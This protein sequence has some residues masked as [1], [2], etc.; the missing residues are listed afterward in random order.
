M[1]F[2]LR[3]ATLVLPATM[4]MVS[5]SKDDK[6][7]SGNN[8]EESSKLTT[9]NVTAEAM[10]EDANTEIMVATQQNALLKTGVRSEDGTVT[11]FGATGATGTNG[12]AEVVV[13]PTSDTWPKTVVI[14][15]GTSG[16]TGVLGYTHKGKITYVIT[17]RFI[18][19]GSEITATFENYSVNG[20]KIEGTYKVVNAT[21][22]IVP[23]ITTQVI[24]GKITYPDGTWYTHS[25]LRNFQ[26][27]NGVQTTTILEDDEFSVTGSSSI[28][29]SDG[30][31]LDAIIKTPL[32]KK[33][34]CANIVSGTVDFTYNNVS[35]VWSYGTGDC[36]KIATITVG[37]WVGTITLP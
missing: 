9:A 29:A 4:L 37:N 2:S 18:S 15:Y 5:C 23:A 17:K 33:A 28:T 14:N 27:T 30:R 31:K 25:G 12:C 24:G 32:L 11:T 19:P 16:C 3:L 8:N 26:Q 6:K 20:Y 36:D 13:T 10:F 1:K 34:V 22:G 21:S 35:G 7:D